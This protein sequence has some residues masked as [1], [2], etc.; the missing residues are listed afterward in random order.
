MIAR[1]NSTPKKP[2][3]HLGD[4]P[5]Q[6]GAMGMVIFISSHILMMP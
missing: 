2:I 4:I 5:R 1:L 3:L 6:M